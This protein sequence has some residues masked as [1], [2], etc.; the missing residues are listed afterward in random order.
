VSIEPGTLYVVATPIGNLED[1]TGRGARVLADVDWIAAEDT[2]HSRH[3][4]G[5]L[6]IS[7]SLVSLHEH[8]EHARLAWFVDRL[9][10]GESVA[11]IS[12]AGT[13]LINDPGYLVV[14][15]A[16]RRGYAVVP[17]PGPS[18]VT[19][20]LSVAGLP[21]DAFVFEGFVPRTP[22]QRRRWL[23]RRRTERRTLVM[24]ESSHRILDTV[25]DL[26]EIFGPEREAT[27]LREL[28]K[29]YETIVLDGLGA[30]LVRLRQ[31]PNQQRGEF[32]LV[33]AG[34]PEEAADTEL[35]EG[36][37]VCTIL[38]TELPLA[39]AVAL[40]ARISGARKN[41]LYSRALRQEQEE[42]A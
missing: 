40:A 25:A 16:R 24:L 42:G 11:L 5:H 27:L 7:T 12:D 38:R 2:R 14:R 6:G 13:P 17:V 32:V 4:L 39:Q 21:T 15:E 31:D 41:R 22:A 1:M 20:A 30:H 33:V 3:L 28:T 37:R 19:A 10:A 23:E 9:N 35:E 8:N 26:A 29:V 36:L 34:K 18:A